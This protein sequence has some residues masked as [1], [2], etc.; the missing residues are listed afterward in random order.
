MVGDTTTLA[1]R[2][3]YRVGASIPLVTQQLNV[4]VVDRAW[5]CLRGGQAINTSLPCTV[6]LPVHVF[7][8]DDARNRASN[9]LGFFNATSR[10]NQGNHRLEPRAH[11]L[12]NSICTNLVVEAP[13]ERTASGRT[14]R[15]NFQSP[16][17][18]SIV[19]RQ[20]QFRR[21]N[22]LGVTK[23]SS[24][25]DWCYGE[26]PLRKSSTGRSGSAALDGVR[27]LSGCET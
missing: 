3:R 9:R 4:N 18:V 2:C 5:A 21:P 22:R 19:S 6:R 23:G 27:Q 17:P 8:T 25:C 24:H 14:L 12:S 20:R 11:S 10:A 16:S 13:I 1:H 26:C 7:V 15:I